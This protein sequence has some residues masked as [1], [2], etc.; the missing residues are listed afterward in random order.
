MNKVGRLGTLVTAVAVGVLLGSILFRRVPEPAPVSRP[1]PPPKAAPD[2]QAMAELAVAM[3]RIGAL[4]TQLRQL[5]EKVDARGK[6]KEALLKD[7]KE[8]AARENDFAAEG[9]DE[10]DVL[11]FGWRVPNRPQ[12]VAS[13]LGLDAA[14]RKTLEETYQSFV[15]RIRRLEK[16]HAKTTVDGDTTRIEIEA[17]PTEGKALIDEWSARITAI[18]TPDEKD[19]YKKMGLGLLP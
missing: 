14:R 11:P 7:L 12:S 10:K 6:D 9:F 17:F 8:T 19:K 15:D 4:E 1:A 2:P 16:D 3:E 13:V 18:L 5:Q